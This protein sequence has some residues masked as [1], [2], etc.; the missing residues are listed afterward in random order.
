MENTIENEPYY[1]YSYVVNGQ[2]FWTPSLILAY[3]RSERDV[4]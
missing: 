3:A 2:E 1:I 4:M